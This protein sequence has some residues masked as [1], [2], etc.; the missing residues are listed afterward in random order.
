LQPACWFDAQ[1][2]SL[3]ADPVVLLDKALYGH[4]ESGALWE[5]HL[6]AKLKLDKWE[7][8]EG[9]PGLYTNATL[10]AS[11][12][13]YVD[14]LLLSCPP[15]HTNAI[16]RSIEAGIKFKEAE[17]PL[18]RYLGIQH[19]AV[20]AGR[21]TTMQVEMQSFLQSAVTRYCDEVGVKTLPIVPTPSLD[22]D[23]PLTE[24]EAMPGKQASTCASHLMKVLFAARMAS[25]WLVTMINRLAKHVTH[26][27]VFHD[28]ALR[29]LMSFIAH[30]T[31]LRLNFVLSQ[32]D[33]KDCELHYWPDADNGG[34]HSS[35]KSTSGMWLALLSKDGTRQWPL[36]WSSKKQ[37]AT[38]NSTCE[39]EMISLA[40][41]L[42][43]EVIP[44][45]LLIEKL[46]GRDVALRTH[47]DNT[48]TII[49]VQKGYS[50][51]LRHL[52]RTQRLSVGFVHEFFH[53]HEEE[54]EDVDGY[55]YARDNSKAY[56]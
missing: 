49:A 39:A 27:S 3:W 17:S 36:A 7:R 4:P 34:D 30:N 48:A 55:I 56:R 44:M 47:E 53:G 8:I 19:T 14:D 12:V 1:G 21:V 20:V 18:D 22:Q 38:S 25:P 28:K 26:W 33:M 11:M 51:A 40:T 5:A 29:R 43:K 6:E 16:W 45:W 9:H 54:A 52:P 2:N 35:T 15:Q 32:D 23:T 42:K 31:H 50:P 37:T 41:N 13:V 24:Q 10:R 46:L